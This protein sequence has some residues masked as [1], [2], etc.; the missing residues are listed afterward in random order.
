MNSPRT[1]ETARL[2]Y[3]A[4]LGGEDLAGLSV[5]GVSITVRK[6]DRNPITRGLV[7]DVPH[8]LY[9]M[10]NRDGVLLYVGITNNP[11]GRF[12]TH[13]ESQP[14]WSEVVNITLEH[15]PSRL[16][17]Q[18][19]ESNAIKDE[20]PLYNIARPAGAYVP[21]PTCPSCAS[22]KPDLMPVEDYELL[23]ED[24]EWVPFCTDP[25]HFPGEEWAE[26]IHKNRDLL[27]QAGLLR[28]SAIAKER[29]ERRRG[30]QNGSGTNSISTPSSVTSVSASVL[31]LK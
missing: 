18:A 24:G 20:G 9:R 4:R 19:A 3:G 25:F 22:S 13:S 10:F 26:K 11:K 28:L 6:A 15:L 30:A 23:T 2:P 17:R 16:H 8:V 21:E 27:R 1:P 7:M 29:L 12:R 14:W 31:I 5:R